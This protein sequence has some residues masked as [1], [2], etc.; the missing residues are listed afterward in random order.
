MIIGTYLCADYV[1]GLKYGHLVFGLFFSLNRHYQS[2]KGVFLNLSMNFLEKYVTSQ[3]QGTTLSPL[4]RLLL[5]FSPKVVLHVTQIPISL[6][7]PLP[8][9][10]I[11]LLRKVVTDGV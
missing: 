11:H 10:S 9:I 6:N 1:R 8:P 2:R 7:L 5:P 4:R 3:T